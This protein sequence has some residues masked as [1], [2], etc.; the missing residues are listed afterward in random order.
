MTDSTPLEGP[1]TMTRKGIGFFS[2]GED[3]EDLLIPVEATLHAL[4]GDIVKVEPTGTY[5]DPM[6]RMPPRAS[7]KVVE[8]VRRA[9]ETFVGTLLEN[10]EN[11]NTY[12]SPDHKK[13]HVPILVP[14]LGEATLG[15]K[16][17]VRLTR[18]EA[19]M[20]YPEGIVEEV[21]GRAGMHDVEMRALALGQGFS[22]T[23]PPGVVTEA[24]ELE[25]NGRILL[26]KEAEESIAIGRRRDFRGVPTCTI[27]P[28]D[29]KD[30]DDALSIRTLPDG[31]YEVGVHIADVSF[32]V[33]PGTA[34]DTEAVERAT[35][36]YLVDR[37]IPM[38]PEVLSNDLCSLRP[39]EDR[40]SVSA[41]FTLDKEANIVDQWFGETV[42]HSDKRFTYE[43][44]QEVLNK[45]EGTMHTELATLLTLSKKIRTRRQAN[46]V[47]EFDKP[48][49]KVELDKEGRPIA[50]KLKL[51][52]D[53]NLL[54]EDF[55][56]LAN[57]AV[58]KHLSKL[59]DEC[60]PTCFSLFRVHDEPDAD[61]IENL[62]QLLRVM[63][64]T[65]HIGKGGKVSGQE[66]NA[67]LEAVKGK[68]EEYLV[69]MSVLRSMSKA[70][71]TT[72][73]IGHF[74]LAFDA[75]TTFTSPIRRYPDVIIH[76]LVKSHAGGEPVTTKEMQEFDRLA[77]HASEREVG[78]AEAERDSIKMK[79]VEFLAGHIGE[80][81]DAVISGVT[82]R[83]LYVELNET[84]ADGMILV[85]NVGDDFFEYDEKHYRLVGKRTGKSYQLGNPIKVKLMAARV[86]EKELDFV[87][88]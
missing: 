6:G 81:F 49:V 37:T 41:V 62:A 23:F 30:F 77:A 66:L 64:Y 8:I 68:P 72:R 27:D 50:I 47:I 22:P 33:R 12:L 57:E 51:R 86:A 18:W 19:D 59:T 4:H 46:G 75:Y 1:I 16:V 14:D 2:I 11:H 35:S 45:G 44:A 40:L 83:G 60:G 69:K 9:R 82:D 79:Q 25:E 38:L 39:N 10:T 53:T 58:A 42:I 87:P 54:I 48:E 24:N 88:V 73:N 3:Q 32:F 74:G 52:Q 15:D 76:R 84:H 5:E 34:I 63:G 28:F 36:V 43:E 70:V 56:L 31:N 7:G 67:L 13:M 78:A 26:A 55:M 71:Y 17:L 29:A 65:I 80:E 85:R 21:I 61:R 20:E